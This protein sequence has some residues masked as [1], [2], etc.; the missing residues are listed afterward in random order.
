MTQSYT[1]CEFSSKQMMQLERENVRL[2]WIYSD[3]F[4]NKL[5]DFLF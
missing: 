5:E 1:K 4:V 3:D 2:L